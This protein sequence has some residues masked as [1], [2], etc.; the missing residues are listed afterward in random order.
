MA[1]KPKRNGNGPTATLEQPVE[2]VEQPISTPTGTTALV[3]IRGDLAL[4]QEFISTLEQSQS[5]AEITPED[6]MIP[7]ECFNVKLKD[8]NDQWIPANRFFNTVTEEVNEEIDAALLFLKKSRKYVEWDEDAGSTLMCHSL[9]LETGNWQEPAEFRRCEICPL[10]R[11]TGNGR[12]SEPPKCKL[13]WNFVGVNL[14]NGDPFIVSAKS[15]SM[16][17]VRQFL[18]KYYIGKLRGKNLP[19]FC[20]AVKLKL[21]QPIGTYA[22][23]QPEIG[24][25]FGREDIETWHRLSQELWNSRRIDL[26]QT[27][28]EEV[29][30]P[31]AHGGKDEDVPF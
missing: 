10:Q 7:H 3:P 2:Q 18:N 27:P 30:M 28:P 24:P 6:R 11:W 15:T 20:Y 31:S 29:E 14:K 22:V 4:P 1:S 16:K 25:T 13:V 23:L 21:Y 17:P 26:T 5:L 12:N 19:L 9:D 8:K